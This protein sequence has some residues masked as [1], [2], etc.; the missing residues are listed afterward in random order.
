[1]RWGKTQEDNPE[2]SEFGP[3]LLDIEISAG[4]CSGNCPFCY[5]ENSSNKQSKNMSLDTFKKILD[6]I[7][8]KPN[9]LCQIAFG[10]TGVQTNDAFIPMMEY[11][12][13]KGIIPNFTLSGADLTPELA[14]K[15]A[16]LVGGLAVSVY[17][18]DK[19]IGYNTVKAF[20]D[21]GVK[22]VNIHAFTSIQTLDFI[23]EI[24]NDI[25]TD[26][27]LK[28]LNAVIF[29]GMK[30]KGR[31]KGHF[32]SVK[33]EDYAKLVQY[34]LDKNLR[35]GFDSCSAPKFE[36][37]IR[38]SDKFSE[39]Q[40]AQMISMSESCESSAF[41][42]YISVDGIGWPCS[43]A[44][45]ESGIKSVNMLEIK[46]FLKD[47]WYGEAVTDFRNRLLKTCVNSCRNCVIYEV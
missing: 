44:E 1:M 24:L 30:P 26:E 3:E 18:T 4:K 5:K 12:R 25:Q 10:I 19:N 33:Q 36:S 16:P 11:C 47:V 7:T 20:T 43:F 27:R 39:Q 21:R 32:H 31:A 23:Y 34:C 15:I 37:F 38:S 35:F 46:D 28:K 6:K 2:F 42:F 8:E 14:D 45:N 13:S 41:S 29:L 22:Q 40:K 9:P 17:Q